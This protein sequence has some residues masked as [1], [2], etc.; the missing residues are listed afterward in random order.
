MDMEEE[1]CETTVLKLRMSARPNYKGGR[2]TMVSG[3]TSHIGKRSKVFNSLSLRP[4]TTARSIGK[5][6]SAHVAITAA[7]YQMTTEGSQRASQRASQ[8]GTGYNTL[9]A[10]TDLFYKPKRLGKHSSPPL[11]RKSNSPKRRTSRPPFNASVCAS[12][13]E[14]KFEPS[15]YM[16]T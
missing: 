12:S 9:L 13:D 15:K 16:N 1:G 10:S 3:Q 6:A 2:P 4:G 7:N 14:V 5:Q 8:R 11:M